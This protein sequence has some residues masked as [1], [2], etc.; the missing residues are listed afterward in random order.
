MHYAVVYYPYKVEKIKDVLKFYKKEIIIGE[1]PIVKYNITICNREDSTIIY[2]HLKNEQ[3]PTVIPT[4]YSSPKLD[5]G[6]YIVE[7]TRNFYEEDAYPRIRE[8]SSA[9]Q[10][11]KRVL[12]YIDTSTISEDKYYEFWKKYGYT[13]IMI[14]NSF[15][16]QLNWRDY[17]EGWTTLSQTLFLVENFDVE[18]NSVCMTK[19]EAYFLAYMKR[20]FS[21]FKE[22]KN[23]FD[24]VFQ[25]HKKDRF[26]PYEVSKI[27]LPSD[28][29]PVLAVDDNKNY[30]L[31][32]MSDCEKK[33]NNGSVPI[34]E[35]PVNFQTRST[36]M[37]GIPVIH[38]KEDFVRKKVL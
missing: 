26:F 11:Y 10:Y 21:L 23:E 7:D 28:N 25:G 31:I 5:F 19:P 20:D 12:A 35:I 38:P 14:P 36:S 22:L 9:A 30:F 2:F 27:S 17:C 32:A 16:M 3:M 15:W 4:G 37:W 13:N 8:I 29:W 33:I 34:I 6:Y 18:N 1:W 24:K